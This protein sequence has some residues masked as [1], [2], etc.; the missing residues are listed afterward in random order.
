MGNSTNNS[1]ARIWQ[2]TLQAKALKNI[3]L[4]NKN[5]LLTNNLQDA[6][7]Q[8]AAMILQNQLL[9][10]QLCAATQGSFPPLPTTGPED[11]AMEEEDLPVSIHSG[12]IHLEGSPSI[13]ST[14]YCRK[15]TRRHNE[16]LDGIW[17]GD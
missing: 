3:K 9:Q 15:Q 6:L 2:H 4:V 16:M 1:E 10:K 11:V 13:S 8:M 17:P 14:S 7:D 12:G 5:C